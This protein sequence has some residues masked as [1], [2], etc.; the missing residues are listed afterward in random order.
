[1]VKSCE[2]MNYTELVSHCAKNRLLKRC[3]GSNINQYHLRK[4]SAKDNEKDQKVE[5]KNCERSQ[6]VH[7][8]HSELVD[9]ICSFI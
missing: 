7:I 5:H 3:S 2:N 4:K 6:F 1:M 9:I 8:S